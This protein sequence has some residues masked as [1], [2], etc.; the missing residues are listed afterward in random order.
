[1]RAAARSRG[2]RGGD[3]LGNLPD[4]GAA[5]TNTA[6]AAPPAPRAPT[7]MPSADG[8]V[9]ETSAGASSTQGGGASGEKQVNLGGMVDGSGDR[10]LV[11]LVI[12]QYQ[13]HEVCRTSKRVSS[14]GVAQTQVVVQKH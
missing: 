11:D 5:D 10:A 7:N 2:A 12:E 3:H 6:L 13:N 9:T 4:R 14:A 8:G 1:M